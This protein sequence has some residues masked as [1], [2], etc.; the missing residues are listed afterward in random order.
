MREAVMKGVT[1]NI[2]GKTHAKDSAKREDA[3]LTTLTGFSI[4]IEETMECL[5]SDLHFEMA[6]QVRKVLL[7]DRVVVPVGLSVFF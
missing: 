1:H 7:I 6:Q 4:C 5:L 3:L 2:R